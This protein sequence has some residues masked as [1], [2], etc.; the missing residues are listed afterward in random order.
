MAL[1]SVN[2]NFDL[3]GISSPECQKTVYL[4]MKC[5]MAFPSRIVPDGLY[6]FFK[7]NNHGVQF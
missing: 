4:S 2:M 7:K 5:E 3:A 1:P 6:K